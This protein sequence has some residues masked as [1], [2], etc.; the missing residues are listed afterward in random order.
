[1]AIQPDL[2]EQ[3][4]RSDEGETLDFKREQYPFERADRIS[5]SELLKDLL[6]FANTQGDAYILVGV[7]E[8]RGTRSEV[9][10]VAEHLDDAK[11]Q[12]FV[13]SK[14]QRPVAFSYREATHDDL[15]IGVLHIPSRSGLRYAIRDYGKVKKHAVYVRRGSSTAIATPDEIAQMGTPEIDDRR[16]FGGAPG[17]GKLAGKLIARSQDTE[18]AERVVEI[19][20]AAPKQRDPVYVDVAWAEHLLAKGDER[21]VAAAGDIGF[22]TVSGVY[23][24]EDRMEARRYLFPSGLPPDLGEQPAMERRSGL[25]A[26]TEVVRRLDVLREELAR[27]IGRV[28]RGEVTTTA[29]GSG[30]HLR[31]ESAWAR[32]Y[33]GEHEIVCPELDDLELT[34]WHDLLCEVVPMLDRGSSMREI[35]WRAELCLAGSV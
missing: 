27:H 11:L 19:F 1:M 9:V 7:E 12:E 6:A 17:S 22:R 15:S 20:R 30:G 2:I 28:R 33:F 29:I 25:P 34:R 18:E 14:T 23:S 10:G 24:D 16:A 3:L 21:H 13:S 8:R 35:R 32:Q 26:Q 4:L 31:G 5:K